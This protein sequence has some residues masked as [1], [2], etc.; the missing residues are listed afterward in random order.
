VELAG[1]EFRPGK[2]FAVGKNYSIDCLIRREDSVQGR[3]GIAL[4][5]RCRT[6]SVFISTAWGNLRR[7]FWRL[8]DIPR[9]GT[10]LA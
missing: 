9:F 5:V 7:D 8:L 2:N 4:M 1:G 3:F 10:V 6:T